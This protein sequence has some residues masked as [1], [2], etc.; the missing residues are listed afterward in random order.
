MYNINYRRNKIFLFPWKSIVILHFQRYITNKFVIGT[1]A[2]Y[3]R[4]SESNK[5][6]RNYKLGDAAISRL[7]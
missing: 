4:H 7:Y 3:S 6:P 5:I 1:R 2:K